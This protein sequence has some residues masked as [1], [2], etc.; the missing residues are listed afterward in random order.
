MPHAREAADV[1]ALCGRLEERGGPVALASAPPGGSGALDGEAGS[2]AGLGG[3]WRLV[4]SS[5]FNSGSLGGSRPG[6]P[7]AFFPAVL[8]GVYQRIDPGTATLDNIVELLPSYGPPDLGLVR[9]ALEAATGRTANGTAGGGLLG[10]LADAAAALGLPAPPALPAEVAAALPAPLREALVGSGGG[11]GVATSGEG[12]GV[13]ARRPR[14]RLETPA[15]RLTLRHSYELVGTADVRIVYDETYG[16]LVGSELFAGLPRLQAPSL[17]EP[18]RP[19]RVLRWVRGSVDR[20]A[21]FTVTYLDAQ[22]RISRGD[23]GELRIYL[24][25]DAAAAA[26]GG[27]ADGPAA[28]ALDYQD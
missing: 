24:R 2:A 7:A 26:V 5:G 4:Y 16:E 10:G 6:P 11:A 18:L 9:E 3:T 13:A 1:D 15:A 14:R 28:A 25:D 23:R 21:S 12:A 17:P 8:G 27:A 20:S 19:P 22:L